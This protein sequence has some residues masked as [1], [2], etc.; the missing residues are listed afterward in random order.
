MCFFI[1]IVMDDVEKIFYLKKE[2]N[3]VEIIYEVFDNI[4]GTLKRINE[5]YNELEEI[6][7]KENFGEEI[8]LLIESSK[9]NSS[10]YNLVSEI[11]SL[12]IGLMGYVNNPELFE[13]NFEILLEKYSLLRGERYAEKKKENIFSLEEKTI[14]F[15]KNFYQTRKIE[16]NF[17]NFGIK[18]DEKNQERVKNLYLNA[19]LLFKDKKINEAI[20]KLMEIQNIYLQ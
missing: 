8:S 19:A 1:I 15:I 2:E 4:Y 3:P 7:K 12:S 13:K 20:D 17:K 14:Q 10:L 16:K 6:V 9:K 11:S 5:R 18:L